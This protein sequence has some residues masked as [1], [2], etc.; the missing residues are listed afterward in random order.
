MDECEVLIVGGGPAGSSCAWKLQRAG[1]DTVILDKKTFP[2]D[3][4]CGGW[5]TPAV[6]DALE[7][8]RN[9]YAS[10]RVLQ[11]ITGFRTSCMGHREVETAYAEPISYG[12][13]RC[14]F[15]DY[16]LR[17]S[18]ARVCEG[19]ALARLERF[20]DHWVVNGR[21]KAKVIVGAGGHFCPVA[22]YLGA[23]A[24][25]EAAVVAQETE[26]ELSPREREDCSIQ[27]EVP[28]L[29]FCPDM[30]GY[31][32]C[33]RKGNFLN[34]GVGRLD[35]HGLPQ[36]VADFMEFLK[37]G[38]K[39]GV[40]V[41]ATMRGHAYLLYQCHRRNVVGDGILLVGDSAGLAYSQSGEGIRPAVES[42][43]LAADCILSAG[44][45]YNQKTLSP[46]SGLLAARF[47]KIHEDWS[48]AVG[49]RVPAQVIHSL[50]KLLLGSRW[51]A[52]HVILD[53]WFLHRHDPALPSRQQSA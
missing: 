44:R 9:E 18:G 29:Y 4:I 27:G 41:T 33:F 1:L 3:K 2:R 46:Y 47:G 8:D 37:L 43:L 26:F 21:I 42:G 48:V 13:R 35:A 7:V 12:I 40:D 30:K 53:R 45:K 36:Q 19:T 28:E 49:R 24:R 38:R 50:S 17:R 23:D 10:G 15:D 5:I 31:G 32:W 20:S 14:E 25:K 52:R 22:R 6:L 11:S 16:L 39:L 51:F 34:I